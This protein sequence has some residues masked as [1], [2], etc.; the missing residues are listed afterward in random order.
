MLL[1]HIR[2]EVLERGVT[3]MNV[4]AG[5]HWLDA[6]VMNGDRGVPLFF[7]ISGF[8]LGRPFLR[9]HRLGGHKVA[10][11]KYY[12]RRLTRLEPPYVL[13][14]LIYTAAAVLAFPITFR[15]LLPNLLASIVYLHGPIYGHPSEINFVTWSL[16]VEVQFYVLAPLLGQLFRIPRTSVRRSVMALI[17]LGWGLIVAQNPWNAAQERFWFLGYLQ[18]FVAGF[19]LVDLL[20]FPRYEYR[21]SRLWDAVSVV[22]WPAIFLLSRTTT[23]MGFLPLLI[24]PAYVAAFRGKA[25]NWV[26]RQPLIALTGGMCYTIYLFH[27]LLISIA[28]RV[29]KHVRFASDG[30]TLAVEGLLLLLSVMAVAPV[31]FVL[32]ERPC[33]DPHW[34]AKLAGVVRR[35]FG[36][37]GEPAVES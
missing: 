28:F 8:I 12:L 35:R 1:F 4:P 29:I 22:C 6:L 34:P 37:T 32:V 33:M 18:Y 30:A 3:R 19:L 15:R 25:S 10:L 2:G 14:L 31:I 9:Q 17:V 11:G 23:T 24:V 27:M 13:S 26:F 36:L 20:E 5:A 21:G 7:V 16:E